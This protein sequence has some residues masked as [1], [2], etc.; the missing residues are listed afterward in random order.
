MLCDYHV[1]SY[2]SDD[3]EYLME[4]IVKDAIKKGIQELCFCD[5]V[6]Y[7]VKM[8]AE[9]EERVEGCVYNVDYPRYFQEIDALKE[10]YKDQITLKRGMEFGVQTHT[11]KQFKMLYNFWFYDFII[12]SCHQ[13]NDLEFWNQDFQRGKSQAE[14]NKAYYQNILSVV[15]EFKDYSVLGHLDLIR[16]YDENGHYPFEFVKDI[17]EEI[18]KQIILDGKGIEINTSSF[19][20]GLD[21]LTPARDILSLYLKLGGEIITI[22]S[23]AHNS[24]QLGAYIEGV[25]EILKQIGFKKFCTYDKMK[26]IFHDL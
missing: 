11:I 12:L 7:G 19:Y 23:D 20:Y 4:D 25:K 18:L 15:R 22:G 13:I 16:R 6:D 17:V 10:K 14:Y 3:C 26:P 9:C 8:D 24:E 5:H 1:H 2:Y 21:D